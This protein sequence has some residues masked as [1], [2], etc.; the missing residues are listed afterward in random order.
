MLSTQ[1]TG[2]YQTAITVMSPA[3]NKIIEN[4]QNWG[5][6]EQL[7]VEELPQNEINEFIKKLDI[8]YPG[9]TKRKLKLAIRTHITNLTCF[10]YRVIARNKDKSIVWNPLEETYESFICKHKNYKI[11]YRSNTLPHPVADI[12]SDWV[13][14]NLTEEIYSD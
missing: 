10:K 1:L 4:Y 8:Y 7:N 9:A 6:T 3:I 12:I 13:N 14:N 2:D 5:K 11:S